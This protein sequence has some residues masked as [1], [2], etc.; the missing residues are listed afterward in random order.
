MKINKY[1]KI[2]FLLLI[3]FLLSSSLNAQVTVKGTVADEK[4]EA[5]IGVTITS[6]YDKK[7]HAVTDLDGKFNITVDSEADVLTFSYLGYGLLEQKVVVDKAMK[8]IMKEDSKYLDEVVVIGYQDV[9]RKDLTGSVAKANIDDML[10][11]PVPNFDQALAGRIAG[12]SVSS[13]SGMPGGVMN[14]VIRGNN[15]VTQENSPM[16]IIDGFPVEDPTIGAS[17]NPN[18]IES[19]DVLKDAS[20]AAIYG[21][22]GANGVIIITTK[23]GK[24]G[25]MQINYDFNAGVQKVRNKI[26]LMNAHQF[27]KLQE[28][29]YTPDEMIREGYGYY[30]TY[31]GKTYTLD[32]YINVP[33]YDWQDLIFQ[34]AWQQSHNL[35]LTGGNPELR[36]NASFSYFD[37]DGVIIRSNYNKIQGRS[38]VRFRKGKL[39]AH[40]NVNYSKAITTGNSPSQSGSVSGMNNLFFNVWGYR[41]VTQPGT[42]LSSLLD[43]IRDESINPTNDYRFNPYMNLQNEHRKNAVTYIQFDGFA[44]YEIIKGLKL[45]A[46]GGYTID[47]RR[48]ET[49]NNSKTRYGYPGSINGVNATLATSERNTWLNENTLSY[50]TLL[51][52]KHSISSFIG[53]TMQESKYI[54]NSASSKYIPN[55]SLGMAGM[56]QGTP[57]QN[58]SQMSDWGMI[59]YLGR[60]NYNFDS[61]YYFTA[62]FRADGSSKFAPEN[63]WGYFPSGSV[64][65]SF[66]EESFMSSLKPITNMGKIRMSWGKTGNNRI[67][68]YDRFAQLGIYS[69]A[70]GNYTTSKGIP[71]SVYP[72]GGDITAIG[73]IP[74][75]LPNKDLKWETT[76]QTNIGLDLALLND[77]ITITTDWYNKETSDLLLYANIPLSTGYSGAMKNVGKV[78]NRGWEFSLNTINIDTKDF[79]W[80]TNFNIA[81]NRNKVVSLT[82]GEESMLSIAAFDQTFN[83]MPSYIAKKGYPIGMMYGYIYDGTYKL[84]EFDIVGDKYSLKANVPYFASETNTQPGYPK[85]VDLNKDGVIDSSDR[86]IIG[87][88]EPK[89]IGGFTNNFEYKGFDLSIFLQWSYG[90]EILNAN[91]LMFENGFNLRKDLNQFASFANR[92]TFDNPTSNIP[93]VSASPSNVVFSSRVMEDGSYLR[94]KTVSLGYSIPSEL[95]KKIYL[96]KARVYFSAQNLFTFSNYSGYDPEV[97]V[98]NSAITPGLDFSAY[99]RAASFNFGVNLSF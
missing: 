63:R 39:N 74:I 83:S 38:G 97:S 65:W 88:G 75:S 71:K 56:G 31:E 34:D 1:F 17:I 48:N 89:H 28:E 4:G 78:N 64:A 81:F 18:D 87:N 2:T 50:Q 13:E 14:I 44:E 66:T 3:S 9:K 62:S 60:F 32:D 37:Q 61:K 59:S 67:G 6:K 19:I 76:T 49:F 96:T 27:V 80:S 10:K 69:A 54:Y 41:P 20:A 33:Q 79:K 45:K 7:K 57:N 42:P 85:Y 92:W 40:V 22:R 77:R 29:M 95:L 90:N 73:V 52:K 30:S 86:T 12:V 99:P 72:I 21:S 68:D 93:R 55:E 24:V 94:I 53:M 35:S 25:A 58:I 5:L 70:E 82:E 43:N 11:A 91:K 47:N 51:D 23:K 46:S 15:S 8:V 36:Y 98:R 16:F 84:D 26:K